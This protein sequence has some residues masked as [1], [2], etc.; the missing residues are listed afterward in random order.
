VQRVGRDT[1]A[2]RT[3]DQTHLAH[4]WAETAP[5]GWSRVASIVSTRKGYDRTARLLARVNMAMADGY[6][7]S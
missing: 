1:S 3:A 7:A 6:I 2:A 5:I 4:F